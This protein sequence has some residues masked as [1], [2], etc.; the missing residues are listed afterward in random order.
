MKNIYKKFK[1]FSI[2]I[3]ILVINFLPIINARVGAAEFTMTLVVQEGPTI[4]PEPP[5]QEGPSQYNPPSTEPEPEQEFPVWLNI[6]QVNGQYLSDLTIPYQFNEQTL[7]FKGQTNI[8]DAIVLI[9]LNS[10]P[11][12]TYTTN[13]YSED[14]YWQW[15][16]PYSLDFGFHSMEVVGM[17][18]ADPTIT[19]TADLDFEIVKEI[20]PPE[21]P[22]VPLEEPELPL[23]PKEPEEPLPPIPPIPIEPVYPEPGEIS[24]FPEVYDFYSLNIK[25]LNRGK[26]LYPKEKLETE[27]DLRY[28]GGKEMQLVDLKYI[29]LNEKQEIIME[30]TQQ[31]AVEERVIFKKNFI[32][33]F[34]IKP[35][36]YTI[37]VELEK[38]GSIIQSSDSFFVKKSPLQEPYP[39]FFLGS[40][41][42]GLNSVF[43]IIV[44][45]GLFILFF[46]LLYWE[47]R[48]S[49]KG[50][51]KISVEDLA[52]QHYLDI[53]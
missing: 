29:V 4:Q 43:L 12:I 28:F 47:E 36:R 35:G 24:P 51:K 37:I 32:T 9:R 33:A 41:D 53:K 6:T 16:M 22:E 1:L 3:L 27:T 14:G 50:E 11:N 7:T 13:I 21:E 10:N 49:N 42:I 20:I 30:A 5:S 39:L 44:L 46:L 40:L 2:I 25:V 17:S 23:L 26:F 31:A 52:N 34:T 15:T 38:D 45:S 19:A 8:I 48:K 18:P